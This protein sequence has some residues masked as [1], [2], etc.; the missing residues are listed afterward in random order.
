MMSLCKHTGWTKLWKKGNEVILEVS[1]RPGRIIDESAPADRPTGLILLIGNKTKAS[2]LAKFGVGY[3]TN[4]LHRSQCE[5]HLQMSTLNGLDKSTVLVADAEWPAHNRMPTTS[6]NAQCHQTESRT[7]SVAPAAVEIPEIVGDILHRILLPFADVVC[8]FVKDIG[9]VHNTAV[10]LRMLLERGHASTSSVRPGL[11]LVTDQNDRSEMQA[12]LD[13]LDSFKTTISLKSYFQSI[14]IVSASAAYLELNDPRKR[15]RRQ[16]LRRD[17]LHSLVMTQRTRKESN[18]LFSL[19][20][21]LGLMQ[22][23]ASGAAVSPWIA[24]DF[25]RASRAQ[26][27]VACDLAYHIGHFLQK[28][29]DLDASVSDFV[30]PAVA[31]SLLLDHYSPGMHPFDP[32][33]VFQTLYQVPIFHAIEAAMSLCEA[34]RPSMEASMLVG[35]IGEEMAVQFEQCH[36]L[37]GA[38]PRDTDA[39]LFDLDVCLLC[40]ASAEG[41]R[42]RVRPDTA[43][44]RV[45]SLDGGGVRAVVPLEFLRALEELVGLPCP[46]QRH[47]DVVFGTSSG[48]LSACALYING[49]TVDECIQ[50]LDVLALLSFQ[51]HMIIRLC[52]FMV[53]LLPLMPSLVE[54]VLSLAIGSKYSAQPL[55]T[56]LQDVYGS[57]RSIMDADALSD[58]GAMLGVTL[59]TVQG[60]NTL[61]ATS[62]NGVGRRPH[63]EDYQPLT[64]EKGLSSAPLYKI[65]YPDGTIDGDVRFQDGGLTF[66][67]PA[68]IAIKEVAALF[69]D[70]PEPS[71]V[72][73]LG[74]G[75]SQELQHDKHCSQPRWVATFPARLV[76]AFFKQADC[77]RAWKQVVSQRREGQR[78]K[79]VRLDVKFNDR[80]PSLDDTSP[81]TC[82][83]LSVTSNTRK[84]CGMTSINDPI[85]VDASSQ[86]TPAGKTNQAPEDVFLPSQTDNR[87]ESIIRVPQQDNHG[88][89]CHDRPLSLDQEGDEFDVEE[90]VAKGRIRKRVWY[91]VKWKGY[92]ESDNSWVKKKD[93]GTEVIGI[94]EARHPYGQGTFCFERIVSK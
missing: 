6:G 53:Q 47:F 90:L 56:I 19:R 26:E 13:R 61:V 89:Q 74:T 12:A 27:P 11:F 29:F 51:K 72:V 77:N 21:N 55:E 9:G 39:Y 31:S 28:S 2:V 63:D 33:Q 10:R 54:L 41:R 46:I 23:S 94:Y 88:Q 64:T 81:D 92:P 59:T 65:Y 17:L 18:I 49:W 80:Q 66:N 7:F 40:G 58:M 45:L 16:T 5:I 48:A 52:L 32:R 70:A 15:K 62:Y 38:V 91:K 25:I 86:Q 84:E 1:D 79:F 43:T 75:S 85:N 76:R 20:H 14:R 87:K 22:L 71:I 93:I 60:T 37:N 68:S 35:Q 67:N 4:A 57:R 50:Y 8:I 34:S 24:L 69:P 73:S 83:S 36:G 42:I 78:G 44:A 30:V 82:D 3:S